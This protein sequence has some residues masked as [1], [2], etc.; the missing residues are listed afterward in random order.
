MLYAIRDNEKVEAQPKTKAICQL[1]E[2]EVFSKCGEVNIWHWA[3][4]K[5]ESCDGWYEP[6]TLWH[7][8]WKLIFGK[9]NS[10]IV[11]KKE[12]I[13]HIADVYTNNDV[14]I[15]LQN[16]PIQRQIIRKRENFYGE[17]MLWLI[18]GSH[19]VSNF[20]THISIPKDYIR[21]SGE[22]IN[23]YTGKARALLD[24]NKSKEYSFR[25]SYP[26]RSW[27]DVQ[28]PIFID[29]GEDKLFWI[30][31]GMGTSYGD[32]VFIHKRSFIQKY[33]GD[34]NQ[35]DLVFQENKNSSSNERL[36]RVSLTSVIGVP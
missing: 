6:E 32:G 3:H 27:E 4:R 19:F 5:N 28:R 36:N 9:E 22:L 11:I 23:I 34:L 35:I 8:N 24:D 33:G 18:N 30:K 13:R 16:S 2:R 17:R 26:R 29:F 1:C 7:K 31:N 10:E 12:G 20:T 15:E 21:I 14:V 25:W